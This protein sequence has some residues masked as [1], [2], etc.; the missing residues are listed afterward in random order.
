[1]VRLFDQ[2]FLDQHLLDDLSRGPD[3]EHGGETDE[4]NLDQEN[5]GKAVLN[6][7]TR[8]ASL[9]LL[10]GTDSGPRTTLRHH[11]N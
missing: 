4:Q 10:S 11:H 3:P 9:I 8:H 6:T 7:F 5:P 1:M 2:R